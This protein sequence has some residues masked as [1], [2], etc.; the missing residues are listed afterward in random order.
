MKALL[1]LHILQNFA[2]SNLNRDDTNSPKDAFFGGFRRARISSQ[3]L[4]RAMRSYVREHQLLAPGHLGQRTKRLKE[5]LVSLLQEHGHPAED[6]ARI[7]DH[8]LGGMGLAVKEEG[9]TQYL[10]FLGDEEIKNIASVISANWSQLVETCPTPSEEK[11]KAKSSKDQ[12]KDAKAAVPDDV[13][14]A[15]NRAMR[16]RGAGGDAVDLALFGRM[17]ADKPEKNQDA[18]C[19]VAHAL[20][21]HRVDREFDFFTAVDDRKPEDTPGADM[22]GTVEFNSACYYRYLNVD[23]ELLRANLQNDAELFKGGLAAF[24]RASILAVPSGKQNSHAA[25]NPPSFIAFAIRK[26]ASPRNLANSFAKPATAINGSLVGNSLEKLALEW[27]KLDD[28]FG[29]TAQVYYWNGSES[30]F[31]LGEAR[32]SCDQ[33]VDSAVGAALETLGS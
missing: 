9:K 13:K 4:K 31:V 24:L 10:I 20:S 15:L 26:N 25:H 3:C 29:D 7:C 14:K 17:L 16:D 28:F 33:L 1:E 32:T 2:P 8:A 6:C 23:L 12:K 11:G 5:A 19:Q 27:K 18:A 22:L 21:T 30:L